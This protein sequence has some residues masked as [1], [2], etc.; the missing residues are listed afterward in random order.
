MLVLTTTAGNGRTGR[1]RTKGAR[2]PSLPEALAAQ[3]SP[4][5]A[6]RRVPGR[7]GA[8]ERAGEIASATAARRHGGLPVVPIR[9]G[10]RSA[11]RRAAARRG[12]CPAPTPIVIPRGSC[13]GSSGAGGSRSP[14]KRRGRT[15]AQETRAHLGVETQRRR[16]DK[17]G[18]RTT[19]CLLAL[20]SVVTLPATGLPARDRR[21][22]ATAAWCRNPQP[23]FGD[24]PAAV[25]RAIWRERGFVRSR[26]RGRGTKR[27]RILP[28]PWIHALSHAA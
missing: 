24:A 1:P 21:Q 12:R 19:P 10:R 8:D 18:A 7:H 6:L 22:V 23:T 27:R 3:D 9:W 26:R 15:S 17:A 2:P 25:R 14:P 13:A 28:A 5:Q 4:W 20:F 11:I 16:S